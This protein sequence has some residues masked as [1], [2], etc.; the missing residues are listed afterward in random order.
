[1]KR[2]F[3]TNNKILASI[4]KDN[5]ILVFTIAFLTAVFYYFKE[6]EH[7]ILNFLSLKILATIV[8]VSNIHNIII[9]I[10]Y[11][12]ENKNTKVKIDTDYKKIIIK[13]DGISRQ[14]LFSEIKTSVYNL[15]IYYKNK[16]DNAKRWPILGSDL[17]YWKIEFNNG[18]SV[19]LSNLLVDFLHD[20]P[21]VKNTK[22]RFIL[23]PIIR[24]K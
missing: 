2:T 11:Y 9:L 22:Y 24:K 8:F 12:K 3:R 5:I 17:G 7:F 21:I 23:F 20:K 13:K 16:L 19:Y 10:S 4:L 15:G 18:D 14:Y 6:G 1:M